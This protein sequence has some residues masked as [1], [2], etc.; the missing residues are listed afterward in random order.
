[1][2]NHV[3]HINVPIELNQDTLE[4]ACERRNH[5]QRKR[6]AKQCTE[7]AMPSEMPQDRNNR[8]CRER[9]IVQQTA[10][11]VQPFIGNDAL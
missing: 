4:F 7:S 11:C 1:M 6:H 8:L 3:P 2:E 9:Q 10:T 5:L